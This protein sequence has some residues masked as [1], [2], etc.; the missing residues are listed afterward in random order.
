MI[1]EPI[2]AKSCLPVWFKNLPAV[3]NEDLSVKNNALT[4]KRCMPF[5]DA[6]TTGWIIPLAALPFFLATAAL[7]PH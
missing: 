4:I 2:P 7:L 6:L 1:A 3:A 5:I